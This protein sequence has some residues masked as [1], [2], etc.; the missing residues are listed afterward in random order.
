MKNLDNLQ[1]D[2]NFEMLT[3]ENQ[4]PCHKNPKIFF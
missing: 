1:V 2:G 4:K 3:N